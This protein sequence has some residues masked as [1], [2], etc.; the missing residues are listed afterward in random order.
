MDLKKVVL[1]TL[2]NHQEAHKLWMPNIGECLT[3]SFK[4]PLSVMCCKL[5]TTLNFVSTLFTNS[6]RYGHPDQ[7]RNW[8]IHNPYMGKEDPG[9]R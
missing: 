7:N 9:D 4:F 3:L 5:K 8:H 2:L 1:P 6:N